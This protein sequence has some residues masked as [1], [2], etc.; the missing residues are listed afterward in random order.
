MHSSNSYL[1]ALKQFAKDVGALKVLVCDSHPTQ[2]KPDAKEF[3]TQIGTTLHVLEAETLWANRAELYVIL[4]KE[5]TR[6]DM[7]V[8]GSPLVLWDYCMEQ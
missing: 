7:R 3:C 8:S 5:A 2:T 6:K 1:L 4:M